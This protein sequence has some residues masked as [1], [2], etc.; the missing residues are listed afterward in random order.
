MKKRTDGRLVVLAW[1]L[2]AAVPLHAAPEYPPGNADDAVVNAFLRDQIRSV[3]D[4]VRSYRGALKSLTQDA[5]YVIQAKAAET[6]VEALL[7][8]TEKL[9]AENRL[10]ESLGVAEEANRLIVDAIVLMRSGQTVVVSLSFDT[11]AQEFAY[12]K[13]RFESSEV[14]ISMALDDGVNV[15]ANTRLNVEAMLLQARRQRDLGEREASQG[16]YADAVRTLEGANRQ[17]TRALQALGVPI[18]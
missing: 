1:L 2:L 3:V 13:R 10:K 7:R 18:F 5:K 15:A 4:Q 14:M 12:E 9:A 17:M 6:K 16:N 8:R 11:P